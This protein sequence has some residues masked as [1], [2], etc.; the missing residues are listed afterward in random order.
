MR[1]K[2]ITSVLAVCTTAVLAIAHIAVADDAPVRESLEPLVLNKR[3]WA[4]EALK[5]EGYD[6]VPEGRNILLDMDS[7][8][9]KPG[10]IMAGPKVERENGGVWVSFELDS[11]D[12]IWLYAADPDTGEALHTIA[13]GV[14]GPNAPAPLAKNGLAQRVF[15]D[16]KNLDGNPLAGDAEIHLAVGCKPT[17]ESFIGYDPAQMMGYPLN[18]EVDAKGRVYV[19]IGANIRAEAAILRFDREGKY[20]DMVHPAKPG[21]VDYETME[22]WYPYTEL[23]DGE[24]IPL[25]VKA[26]GNPHF[27]RWAGYVRLPFRIGPKGVGWI[28]HGNLAAWQF[29]IMHQRPVQRDYLM[30]IENINRFFAMP[31]MPFIIGHMGGWALDGK[32]HAYFGMK[33]TENAHKSNGKIYADPNAVG[34]VYKVDLK[35]GELAGTFTHHGTRKLDRPSP[36][37]GESHW[38][39][40]KRH[41]DYSRTEPDPGLDSDQRFV[42]ICG[43]DVDGADNIYVADGYPRPI[44][45]Y[46]QDGRWI[47]ELSGVETNGRIIPFFDIVS[48]RAGADALYVLAILRDKELGAAGPAFSRDAFRPARNAATHLIKFAGQAG[49]LKQIWALKL[50]PGARCVA[51]DR[52]APQPIVWV[53][54]GNGPATLTRIVDHGATCSPPERLGGIAP[55]GSF[56]APELV[57]TDGEGNLFVYDYGRDKLILT[58]DE[59]SRWT[60]IKMP[61]PYADV[62]FWRQGVMTDNSRHAMQP[63]S[64]RVD[65]KHG[66]VLLAADRDVFIS[67]AGVEG[68]FAA[69]DTELNAVESPLLKPGEEERRAGKKLWP[70]WQNRGQMHITVDRAGN[71]YACDTNPD[72]V[73]EGHFRPNSWKVSAGKLYGML[74]VY[75]PE[76]ETIERVRCQT[77]FPAGPMA[78]DSKGDIYI[79]DLV[80]AEYED[81][82]IWFP[83]EIDTIG[84]LA[85][86]YDKVKIGESWSMP[87]RDSW[88][89]FKRGGKPVYAQSD[90]CYLVKFPK[91]GG[92]RNTESELW[93]HR[94]IGPHYGSQCYCSGPGDTV[95]V[96]GAD[97][98]IACDGP[99]RWLKV[100]DTAGN[101]ITRFGRWGNAETVPGKDGFKE[102]GFFQVHSMDAAGDELYVVDRC[103]RRI[104]KF[105]MKYRQTVAVEQG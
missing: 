71:I 45:M 19:A 2:K 99:R 80:R 83:D 85:Q 50:A 23:T 93:A 52:W 57:A 64:L 53:G 75:S 47:G 5:K 48:I 24:P 27:F 51:V 87:P 36:Y 62:L 38:V 76:G 17:F 66:R 10:N 97:R 40:R 67:D 84:M 70:P 96:D 3:A 73:K 100:F 18:V 29:S 28:M 13:C 82:G 65:R 101:L 26:Y 94:G 32:G 37:L 4:M 98:I 92:V 54:A 105:K 44:K 69:Y 16:G 49:R 12:D 35:T 68:G 31:F 91:E 60:E 39:T 61:N 46:R 63:S 102:L 9:R 20:L 78:V 25:T 56:V 42:D 103:L 30:K 88:V 95:V 59:A 8:P 14:L 90:I 1:M 89:R 72:I 21:N 55:M 33:A 22:K 58:D 6:A 15:W 11:A 104:A 77:F 34:T 74:S 41:W 7:W 86:Q 79:M 81:V 43:L